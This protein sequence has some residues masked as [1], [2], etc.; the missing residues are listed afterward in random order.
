MEKYYFHFGDYYG[1]GHRQYTTICC[2]S[3]KTQQE[4]QEIINK[5]DELHPA[6][7]NWKDNGLA[8]QYDEPHIGNE[9]WKDIIK[10]G[11][12]YEK[13]GILLED[14]EFDNY[15]GWDDL[16]ER[17]DLREI[18]VNIDFIMDVFLFVM[19]YYGAELTEVV[20]DHSNHFDFGYGYG[21]FYG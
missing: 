14:L 21:C 13:L 20:E 4:I 19:N 3:P 11:Y 5:I 18:Y 10:L 2:Q 1:D 8:I 16:K 6:F 17:Y 15:T 9:S 12:P 7:N